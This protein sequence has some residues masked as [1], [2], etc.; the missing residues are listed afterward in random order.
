VP[1]PDDD[2]SD[3]EESMDREEAAHEMG[4]A[5]N[6][7]ERAGRLHHREPHDDLTPHTEPEGEPDGEQPDDE[8]QRDREPE[9]G[10]PSEPP[11]L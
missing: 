6:A 5:D 1:D 7:G 9:H 8:E 4:V 3:H 2:T 11:P 10:L